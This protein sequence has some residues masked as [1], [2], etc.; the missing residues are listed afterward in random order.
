[1]PI[2]H[3]AVI[4]QAADAHGGRDPNLSSL[5]AAI[6]VAAD[7]ITGAPRLYNF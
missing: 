1:M 7:A 6:R 4:A 5:T 2:M 3:P